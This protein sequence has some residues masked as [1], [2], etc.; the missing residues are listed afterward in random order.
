MAL[1]VL[2]GLK[3]LEIEF[4]ELKGI[5]ESADVQFEE[6]MILNCRNMLGSIP[7]GCTSV[8]VSS[9]RSSEESSI[10]GQNWD[11]DPLMRDYSIVLTRRPKDKTKNTSIKSNAK[12]LS[13]KL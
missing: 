12:I 13:I 8:L 7:D 1:S 4:N 10:A 11:N 9:E 2:R 3:F 6:L 5:S